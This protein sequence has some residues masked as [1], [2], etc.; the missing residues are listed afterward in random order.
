MQESSEQYSFYKELDTICENRCLY[1]YL[2]FYGGLQMLKNHNIQ[3]TRADKLN[4][5]YDCNSKLIDFQGH[6][7][8]IPEFDKY[9]KFGICSLSK[10]YDNTTLW[11]RK[12]A[13]DD[14][15]CIGLDTKI[16][17]KTLTEKLAQFSVYCSI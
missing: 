15:I 10:S 6:D 3:F 13:N 17:I 5:E 14:G 2:T 16:L 8:L 1:K 4:D 12:Y 9:M 7:Y 11:G